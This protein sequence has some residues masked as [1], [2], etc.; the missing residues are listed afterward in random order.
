LLEL[1]GAVAKH[2]GYHAYHYITL[3]L[4]MRL[5]DLLHSTEDVEVLRML[6]DRGRRLLYVLQLLEGDRSRP[7]I[8]SGHLCIL[9]VKKVK[10]TVS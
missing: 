10:G 1:A 4:T 6:M 2:P 5:L 3:R 9:K 7:F 8:R